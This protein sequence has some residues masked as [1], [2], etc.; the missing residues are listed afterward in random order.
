MLFSWSIY[1]EINSNLQNEIKIFKNSPRA[2][3][4]PEGYE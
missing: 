1:Y 2:F 4:T 3:L